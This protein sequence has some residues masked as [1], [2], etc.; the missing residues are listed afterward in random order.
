MIAHPSGAFTPRQ[1]PYRQGR[2]H[3]ARTGTSSQTMSMPEV[4]SGV[5]RQIRAAPIQP[6]RHSPWRWI[7]SSV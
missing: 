7:A 4:P 5:Q 1:R 3:R 2:Y 6:P